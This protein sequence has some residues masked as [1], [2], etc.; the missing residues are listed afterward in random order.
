MT[1][2]PAY[3]RTGRLDILAANRLGRPCTR[4][5]WPASSCQ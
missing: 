2:V 1:A 3:V 4:P 5:S